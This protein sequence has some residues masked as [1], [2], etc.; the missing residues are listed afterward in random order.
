[1]PAVAGYADLVDA[2]HPLH[3]DEAFDGLGEDRNVVQRGEVRRL[4]RSAPPP[5]EARER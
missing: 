4:V 3:V 5:E 1:M 2:H